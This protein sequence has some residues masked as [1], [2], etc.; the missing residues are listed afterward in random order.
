LREGKE[1]K[2]GGATFGKKKTFL[3]MK[4]N[5]VALPG[6]PRVRGRGRKKVDFQG[7]RR[8]K[9]GKEGETATSTWRPRRPK[10][11]Q[12]QEERKNTSAIFMREKGEKKGAGS[13]FKSGRE[14]KRGKVRKKNVPL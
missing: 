6:D 12:K 5:N 4:H 3:P 10:E 13:P 14:K 2:W 8:K 11:G 9:K 1:R 7:T